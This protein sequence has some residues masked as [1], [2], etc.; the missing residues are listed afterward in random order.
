MLLDF[1]P[2]FLQI[3]GFCFVFPFSPTLCSFE[4]E[5]EL[6][7][8]ENFKSLQKVT[9]GYNEPPCIH[10]PVLTVLTHG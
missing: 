1:L 6:F 10:Q 8:V 5:T 4:I 2:V 7:M 9:D 3:L